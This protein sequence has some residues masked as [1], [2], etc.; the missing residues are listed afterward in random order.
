MSIRPTRRDE[1][2]CNNTLLQLLLPFIPNDLP[3]KQ[4]NSTRLM[5]LTP[6]SQ[7]LTE[8]LLLIHSIIYLMWNPS[9]EV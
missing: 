5:T 6:L 7:L 1:K 2:A 8:H 4:Y 9:Y 3:P